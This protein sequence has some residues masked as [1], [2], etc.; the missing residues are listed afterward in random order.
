MLT[1]EGMTV[2][3]NGAATDNSNA[4]LIKFKITPKKDYSFYPAKETILHPS[5]R[6]LAGQEITVKLIPNKTWA[7]PIAFEDIQNGLRSIKYNDETGKT[8]VEFDKI[9]LKKD[10][11]TMGYI[12]LTNVGTINN[13][14][15]NNMQKALDETFFGK[16]HVV[17][18]NE[19]LTI[20]AGETYP[21]KINQVKYFADLGQFLQGVEINPKNGYGIDVDKLDKIYYNSLFGAEICYD[22]IIGQYTIAHESY[23]VIFQFRISPL[24]E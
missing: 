5:L 21:D 22:D 13:E 17:D 16:S 11:L 15:T 1:L 8:K 12:L 18:I 4:I 23:K 20:D 9:D 3:D 24:K 10:G 19:K 2:D 6:S 7:K 14:V